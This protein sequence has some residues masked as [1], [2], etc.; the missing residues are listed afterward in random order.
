MDSFN[1]TDDQQAKVI[2]NFKNVK[3]KLLKTNTLF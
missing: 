3:E 2:N 1:T